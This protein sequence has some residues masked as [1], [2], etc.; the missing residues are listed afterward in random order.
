[1]KILRA[2]I[3]EFLSHLRIIKVPPSMAMGFLKAQGGANEDSKCKLMTLG[4]EDSKIF[5]SK[6]V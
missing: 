6:E 2:E 1:M 3:A 4:R 5:E